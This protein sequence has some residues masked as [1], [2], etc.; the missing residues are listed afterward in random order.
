MEEINFGKLTKQEIENYLEIEFT[1]EQ[2]DV[3]REE[4]SSVIDHAI[5]EAIEILGSDIEGLVQENKDWEARL[6]S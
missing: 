1:T 6:L 2:W 3:F 5:D 4:L